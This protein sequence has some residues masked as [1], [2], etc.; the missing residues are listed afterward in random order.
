MPI[1]EKMF[2]VMSKVSRDENVDLDEFGRYLVA[3]LDSRHDRAQ[4]S[5]KVQTAIAKGELTMPQVRQPVDL[6]NLDGLVGNALIGIC[7]ASL[8]TA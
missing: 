4:L 7:H 3:L 8:L 6:A 5:D 2:S 1:F